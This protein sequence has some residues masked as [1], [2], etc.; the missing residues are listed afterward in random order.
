MNCFFG[1]GPKRIK[2]STWFLLFKNS[3]SLSLLTMRLFWLVE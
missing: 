2:L 3:H 1:A